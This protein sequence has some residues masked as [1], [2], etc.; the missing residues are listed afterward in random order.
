M[1]CTP[2]LHVNFIFHCPKLRWPLAFQPFVR[3]T[4]VYDCSKRHLGNKPSAISLIPFRPVCSF[5]TR[6][7]PSYRGPY[8]HA[9]HLHVKRRHNI[10]WLLIAVILFEGIPLTKIEK[11]LLTSKYV[12]GSKCA[13]YMCIVDAMR[14]SSLLE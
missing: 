13:L 12:G 4:L 2:D 14:V 10:N 1:P 3:F 11:F 6:T 7:S 9:C 8:N 5:I